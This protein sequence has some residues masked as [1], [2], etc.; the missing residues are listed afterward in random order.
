VKKVSTFLFA[1]GLTSCFAPKVT[2]ED[3]APVS[4]KPK[5]EST[6]ITAVV[7]TSKPSPIPVHNDGLRLPDML[8]LPQDDQL[9]SAPATPKDGKATVI[10]RP[11]EE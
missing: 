3:E 6:E 8:G 7:E 9:R 2:T 4:A 1:I 11:P 10:V 5:T